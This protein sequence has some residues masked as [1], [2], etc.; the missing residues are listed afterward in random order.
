MNKSLKYTCLF[1]GGAIR[2]VSYIGA[3]KAL[4]ELG[5]SPTTFAGSSVGSI[6]AAM[7]AVGY[8]AEEMKDIFLKVNFDLFKDISIGLGPIFALSKG[9]VFLEWV[10]ELIEK[11]FYGDKYKKGLNRAVTFKDIKNNLVV[12]TTNL[13]N[14]E[15]KEFSRFETPDYEIASAVRI[16]CC[17]PGLM[18]PI[19]YNKTLL[20]DGDLQK[21]W[22]MWKL[23]KNLLLPDERILEFR[24][25]GY[26]DTNDISGIDYANAVYSCMTAMSTAFITNIY[27][28]KD[29]FDYIV[30]NTGDIVVVDFNISENK[31]LDL[32]QSGYNQT[33]KYFNS[34][35]PEKKA[36]IKNNY[37][38]IYNHMLKIQKLINSRKILKAKIQLGELFTELC[39]LNNI[40]DLADYNDLKSFKDMFLNHIN[41]P[42]LFGAITLNNEKLIKTELARI[43]ANLAEK[44]DELTSY[45]EIYPLK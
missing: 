8:T 19:E 32:I 45:L 23:S 15:C 4:E 41:Y 43:I 30:L 16:S 21:S 37:Q 35:L 6:I 29:K 2:G 20:V 3:I 14:F 42:P 25:E 27:A 11:K 33:M 5:I 18:K 26:Y 39:D 22:P 36:K 13:S 44:L 17:M 12:I 9:E 34:I 40:I 7:L 1:G 38:I 24:L 31:R 10:R 28:D